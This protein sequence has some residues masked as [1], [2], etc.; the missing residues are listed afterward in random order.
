MVEAAVSIAFF[1]SIVSVPTAA[2]DV[3]LAD[4]ADGTR[5]TIIVNA[6]A[7]AAAY[8]ILHLYHPS[9]KLIMDEVVLAPKVPAT[10]D[11]TS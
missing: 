7:A 11:D 1:A 4:D 10:P 5:T 9:P 2:H 8:E 6:A 3:D